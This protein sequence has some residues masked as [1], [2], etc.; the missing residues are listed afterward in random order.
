MNITLALNSRK[1]IFDR[2]IYAQ[3]LAEHSATANEIDRTLNEIEQE[4]QKAH[5]KVILMGVAFYI[6]LILIFGALISIAGWGD[7][8]AGKALLLV[9]GGVSLIIGSV[10]RVVNKATQV[11]N[12]LR[13]FATDYI[14]KK[15]EAFNQTGLRW[16]VPANFPKT[17]EVYVNPTFSCKDQN[18]EQNN[19]DLEKEPLVENV[20]ISIDNANT[21]NTNTSYQPP[22]IYE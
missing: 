7:I 5:K 13:I 16:T 3:P 20:Q 9:F 22:S 4:I 17:I 18:R 10:F 11:E 6:F 14:K 21:T 15:N 19:L 12:S 1:N 2:T 8:S